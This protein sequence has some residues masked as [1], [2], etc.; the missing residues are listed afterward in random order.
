MVTV[1]SLVCHKFFHPAAA[2]ISSS[3]SMKKFGRFLVSC[4]AFIYNRLRTTP[5]QG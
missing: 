4:Y 2:I 1:S 3:Q 5:R